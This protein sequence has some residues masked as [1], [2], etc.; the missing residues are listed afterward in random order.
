LKVANAFWTVKNLTTQEGQKI[1]GKRFHNHDDMV[2]LH[3]CAVL[4]PRC[5]Q[6]HFGPQFMTFH[7]LVLLKYELALLAVDS[8]IEAMPY[9]NMAFDAVGGKYYQD[10]AKSIFTDKYIGSYQGTGKNQSVVDGLFAYWPIAE[11]TRERFGNISS[12]ST[13]KTRHGTMV[14]R[15]IQEEWFKP[16]QAGCSLLRNHD[17]CTPFVAREPKDR[18]GQS[19]GGLHPLIPMHAPHGMG[20]TFELVYTEA[21]F[22]ACADPERVAT[23]M[24]WQNCVELSAVRCAPKDSWHRTLVAQVLPALLAKLRVKVNEASD[25]DVLKQMI[26]YL[27]QI[28]TAPDWQKN[29]SES[30]MLVGYYNILKQRKSSL[31]GNTTSARDVSQHL[32]G[33]VNFFHSQAHFKM[34]R[35][36]LDVATSPNDAAAFAGYHAD[37]DRNNMH[38]MRQ[39]QLQHKNWTFPA[40]ESTDSG[41]DSPYGASGPYSTYDKVTCWASADG[42]APWSSGTLYNDV[43]NA[44]FPFFN[45]FHCA[46]DVSCD[47]GDNGYTHA[48]VLYWTAPERAPYTYDTLEH[49]YC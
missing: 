15:C 39:S 23:W 37:I 13:Q 5:D 28:Q 16:K 32:R 4:D 20:G 34:G 41:G 11:Y 31:R 36:M 12:M 26:Y 35:D 27:D 9:W 46:D 24:D 22:E 1:Y 45:L 14:N 43:V 8:S 48:E 21:D 17:D 2:M 40:A 38:W 10:P 49:S 25:A 18:T 44:G 7:R 33:F 6:G 29:C 3:V 47:G 30:P 42:H 19:N